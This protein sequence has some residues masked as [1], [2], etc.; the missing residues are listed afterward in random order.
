[1]YQVDDV[2]TK[3]DRLSM[4]HSLEARVPLLD[5]SLMEFAF[6]LPGSAKMPGYQ[7]KRLL[8]EAMRRLLP[9][10]TLAMGKKGFN[11]PLPRWLTGQLR[12]LVAEYL[13]PEVLRRQ[14]Y[15]QPDEVARWVRRH[16]DG[17]AE[18]GRELW[19][20]LMFNLW[21]EEHKAYR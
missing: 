9:A 19:I 17:T 1:V 8:R 13:S 14:G 7:P 12:P 20:L 15:F 4:A 3:I 2:L 6:S 5:T 16:M 10:S 21:V 11:A 18:H